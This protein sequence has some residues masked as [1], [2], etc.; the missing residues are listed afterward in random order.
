MKSKVSLV[1]T[2]ILLLVNFNIWN[3]LFLKYLLYNKY[4]VILK[5]SLLNKRW[6]ALAP[7][8]T[9]YGADRSMLQTETEKIDS[10]RRRAYDYYNHF[11]D[12]R[13]SRCNMG[14]YSD[15]HLLQKQRPPWRIHCS[16]TVFDPNNVEPMPLTFSRL[17]LILPPNQPSV[18]CCW[19]M[20]LDWTVG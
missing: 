5:L 6:A 14:D 18:N 19:Q 20:I 2:S 4:Y 11:P 13:D 9:W 16:L 3:K 15:S 8:R 1:M 7:H 12:H 17:T 10:Q